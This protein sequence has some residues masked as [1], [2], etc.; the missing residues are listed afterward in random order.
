MCFKLQRGWVLNIKNG[1][2]VPFL[3]NRAIRKAKEVSYHRAQCLSCRWRQSCS[4]HSWFVRIFCFSH[5]LQRAIS[6]RPPSR[7][8]LACSVDG[9]HQFCEERVLKSLS[10]QQCIN[11][12]STAKIHFL[13]WKNKFC[14]AFLL[15]KVKNAVLPIISSANFAVLPSICG[16]YSHYRVICNFFIWFFCFFYTFLHDSVNFLWFSCLFHV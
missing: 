8:A 15:L 4:L 2:Y 16:I 1:T 6:H 11:L 7:P 9:L 14:A 13:L 5:Q 12:I 10:I 3:F